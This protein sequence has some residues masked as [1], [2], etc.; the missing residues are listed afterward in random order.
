MLQRSEVQIYSGRQ[1][2]DF[3]GL[4]GLLPHADYIMLPVPP[5]KR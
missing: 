4:V 3:C 2:P 1:V 5:S